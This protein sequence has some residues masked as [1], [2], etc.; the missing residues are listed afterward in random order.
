L[1][2]PKDADNNK[3]DAAFEALL[4]LVLTYIDDCI[5][6][7]LVFCCAEPECP[8]CVILGTIEVVN[9]KICKICTCHR[10]YV[11]TAANL[12]D[13]LLYE[14]LVGLECSQTATATL[15]PVLG[16]TG[17]EPMHQCCPGLEIEPTRFLDLFS[18]D[19]RAALL[20]AKSPIQA[21]R[22]AATATAKAFSYTD[23]DAV[24]SRVF[25]NLNQDDAQALAKKLNLSLLPAQQHVK[26]DAL[27][28]IL[29]SLLM[30]S[31]DQMVLR[32]TD[33]N[34]V[35]AAIPALQ[36]PIAQAEEYSRTLGDLQ[37]QLKEMQARLDKLQP[38]PPP[39][40]P[41]PAQ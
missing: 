9:G 14:I 27:T 15:S 11:W 5:R 13:V 6:Y 34:V 36:A 23:P 21:M 17:R 1:E 18:K 38:P 20:A 4:K 32:T 7:E 37:N 33:K 39:P 28:S 40:A 31:G 8:S 35:Q 16:D 41:P 3:V 25:E 2:C 30:H 26:L 29:P 12:V 10:Q 19:R 22:S 24:S